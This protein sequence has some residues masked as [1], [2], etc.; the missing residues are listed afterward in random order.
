[1]KLKDEMDG[2]EKTIYGSVVELINTKCL[3]HKYLI[4]VSIDVA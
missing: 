4:V 2:K 1:M 3:Q